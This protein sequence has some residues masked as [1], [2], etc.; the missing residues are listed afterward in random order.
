MAQALPAMAA[1]DSQF[2]T[3]FKGAKSIMAILNTS[4]VKFRG[5]EF[6]NAGTYS[7]FFRAEISKSGVTLLFKDYFNTTAAEKVVQQVR[8]KIAPDYDP[9]NPMHK[10]QWEAAGKPDLKQLDANGDPW[11]PTVFEEKWDGETCKEKPL[12]ERRIMLSEELAAQY[13]ST[14]CATLDEAVALAYRVAADSGEFA[15]AEAI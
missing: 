3:K 6:P 2:S 12:Q 15:D 4:T 7:R 1:A 10:A 14:P 8:P 9:E 5:A 11:R 13:L